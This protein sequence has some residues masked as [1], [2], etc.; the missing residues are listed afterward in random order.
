M[1][2]APSP[3]SRAHD[4]RLASL[5]RRRYRFRVGYQPIPV[6]II[7][8]RAKSRGKIPRAG[9]RVQVEA[10]G[11]QG[12]TTLTR[13]PATHNHPSDSRARLQRGCTSS[14]G[15]LNEANQLA[16]SVANG[17]AFELAAKLA[18]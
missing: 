17:E 16:A 14:A 5:L 18:S 7:S 8:P 2:P 4:T 1:P 10:E 15:G 3:T 12:G 11:Q 6:V 9:R 13:R